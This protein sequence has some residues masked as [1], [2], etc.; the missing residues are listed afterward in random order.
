MLVSVDTVL[1]G[2][3]AG[4]SGLLVAAFLNETSGWN[5][6]TVVGVRAPGQKVVT[7]EVRSPILCMARKLWGR[8][9]CDLRAPVSALGQQALR[10]EQ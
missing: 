2:A 8:K 6:S 1:R 3:A 4:E 9:L 10:A 7:L 5:A